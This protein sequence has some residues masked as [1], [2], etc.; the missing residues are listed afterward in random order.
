MQQT[1]LPRGA[2][3]RDI[4]LLYATKSPRARIL[5][6]LFL[7]LFALAPRVASIARA[8]EDWNAFLD[9]LKARG[10]DDVALVYLNQLQASGSAPPELNDE[11]DYAVGAAAFDEAMKAPSAKRDSL[12]AQARDAF[13]KYLKNAPDG[14]KA[15]EANAGLGRLLL[16]QADRLM[17]QTSKLDDASRDAAR[18]QART[19][20]SEASQRILDALKLSQAR[21]KALQSD[22]NADANETRAAQAQFL[23]LTIRQATAAAQLARSF[24]KESDDYVK[25]LEKA[26]ALFKRI[27]EKYQQYSGAFKARFSEAEILHELGRDDEALTVLSELAVLPFEEQFYALKTRSLLLFAEIAI[28]KNDP[29]LLMSLVQKFEKWTNGE[30]LPKNFYSSAEG[31]RIYLLAGKAVVELETLR[32]ENFAAYAAAGKK[33][34]VETDDPTYKLLNATGKKT[35]GSNQIVQYAVKTLSFVASGRSE[36]ALEA[37]KILQTNPIFEGV[38]LEKSSYVQKADSFKSAADIASR[39]ASVFAQARQ[40]ALD[41]APEVAEEAKREMQNALDNAVAAFKVAFDMSARE[42]R[43]D[44]KGKLDPEAAQLAREELNRLYMKYAAITV[45]GE[46]YE[47]A[48]VV[49]D[50]LAHD[51]TFADA[52]QAAVI[53]LRALQALAAN[54]RDREDE[55]DATALDQRAKAYSEFMATRWEGDANSLVGQEASYAQLDAALDSGDFAAARAALDKIAQDSPRR[56]SAELKVGQ[57]YWTAWSARRDAIDDEEDGETEDEQTNLDELLDGAQTN[58]LAGLER[59]VKA[60]ASEDDAPAIF[61]TYLLAQTYVEKDDFANA[62]KWLTHPTIGAVKVCER[63]R[64]AEGEP[65]AALAFVNDSFQMAVLALQLRLL[66]TNVERLEE[67]EKTMAQLDAIAEKSPENAAKLSGVYLAI[68]KRF[69]ERLRALRAS[70]SE[71]KREEMQK[72]AEGFELFLDEASK[73]LGENNS[74]AASR[75]IADSFLA[76]GRGLSDPKTKPTPKAVSYL[77]KARALFMEIAK[78]CQSQPGFAPSDSALSSALLSVCECDRHAQRY[79]RAYKG[80]QA[81]LTKSPDNLD[82]QQEAARLLHAWGA[83]DPQNYVKAIAGDGAGKQGGKLV[84]GWNGIIK[85]LMPTIDKGDRYKELYF[86]AYRGKTRSRYLYVRSI[87]DVEERKRQAQDAE[88]DIKRLYQ[89]RPGM[90]GTASFAYFDRACREFQK[91]RGVAP[92]GLKGKK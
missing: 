68:G 19:I 83:R 22:P 62:E 3:R 24:P 63:V 37:Q 39:E 36:D 55:I 76:L 56:A 27:F 54:A 16:D 26:E 18:L 87:K 12:V 14:P 60:G 10:Y 38:D 81:L 70:D 32:R 46:R 21:A 2:T 13:E 34:F 17:A 59:K 47:D 82:V 80:L 73:R 43:P 84:W 33:T 28:E 78:R 31:R 79:E 44:R 1:S 77:D 86:E 35:S 85:R 92:D 49:A 8:A 5:A 88:E 72:A 48:F 25:G 89:T 40:S 65:P 64:N 75:W 45:S 50:R 58:L 41:A 90:G 29:A 67:A 9:A 69:E 30:K 4:R 71:E 11:L 20:Y 52:G 51:E 42:F 91:L 61:A 66:T 7:F 15:L 6:I 74:Y 53:A 23:D 57:A